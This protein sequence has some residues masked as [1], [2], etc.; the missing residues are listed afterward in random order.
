MTTKPKD[1]WR[2]MSVEYDYQSIKMAG[3]YIARPCEI[4]PHD[5]LA[6]WDEIMAKM[7]NCDVKY[8]ESSVYDSEDEADDEW[9]CEGDE[10]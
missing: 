9:R 10:D 7:E 1:T 3:R 2:I 8:R 5:W 4:S 6:M